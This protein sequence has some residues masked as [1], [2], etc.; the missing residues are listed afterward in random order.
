[1]AYRELTCL[2]LIDSS[3][4][5]H[6]NSEIRIQPTHQLADSADQF[7]TGGGESH[8]VAT[9]DVEAN[10]CFKLLD[11]STHIW[12]RNIQT[13][14]G[15]SEVQLL[16]DGQYILQ[17]SE[18]GRDAHTRACLRRNASLSQP[19]DGPLKGGFHY[20]LKA[21]SKP[22]WGVSEHIFLRKAYFLTL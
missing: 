7:L 2:P 20:F 13:F 9:E 11:L 1:M 10:I 5:I 16:S 12:L 4:C 17:L 14:R 6:C 8:G 19:A 15:S 18:R 3:G 21:L 22:I